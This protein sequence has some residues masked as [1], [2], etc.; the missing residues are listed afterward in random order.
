MIEVIHRLKC[1]ICGNVYEPK[2]L[3]HAY[4]TLDSGPLFPYL[5]SGWGY[6]VGSRPDAWLICPRHTAFFV[7]KT[8]DDALEVPFMYDA[9][10]R[11]TA[12][13]RCAYCGDDRTGKGSLFIGDKAFCDETHYIQWYREE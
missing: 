11:P 12:V 2:E 3:S 8:E 13:V 6:V 1:D 10:M 5:P 9:A 4:K 7:A